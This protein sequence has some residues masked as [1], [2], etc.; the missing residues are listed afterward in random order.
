MENNN[1][2]ET[3]QGI[4]ERTAKASSDYEI[5]N[6]EL[7]RKYL[8]WNIEAFNLVAKRVSTYRGTFGTGYPFYA[9]NSKLEGELPVISEQ[10]RYNREL[11]KDGR[12][13]QK[14]IW[15]CKSCLQRNYKIMPDLKTV[16]KPCPNMFDNFKPR[17]I[18]NRL[19]DIDM[20]IVCEDGNENV[21]RTE[22]ELEELLGNIGMRTSDV[23]PL[24]TLDDVVEIAEDLKKGHNP[25]KYLPIDAHIIEYS[26]IKELIEQ[27][28]DELNCAEQKGKTAYLPIRPKS[29]RKHWQYDD[30]AYNFVYDYLS[31]FTPFNFPKELQDSLDIGRAKVAREHSVD[32][33]LE[34]LT[35]SATPANSRRFDSPDLI[36]YFKM[37]VTEW[38]NLQDKK[39][40]VKGKENEPEIQKSKEEAKLHS[41]VSYEDNNL[42]ER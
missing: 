27:I 5:T 1:K 9:L 17:K 7:K 3:I 11:V 36:R 18:I 22:K 30:A 15:E 16:C 4:T 38:Q 37:R 13:F 2:E 25:K 31:A 28:P 40:E 29:L 35:D 42:E 12:Q 10:I 32:E 24:R 20:W 8:I 34:I 6:T 14:S 19:P 39:I 41:G 21:S 26:K 23:A 33:L